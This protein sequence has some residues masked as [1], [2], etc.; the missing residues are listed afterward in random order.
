MLQ[1][2]NGQEQRESACY[3]KRHQYLQNEKS[4]LEKCCKPKYKFR[5]HHH[6]SRAKVISRDNYYNT[7]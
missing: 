7:K 4:S 2:I 1:C 6:G 5:L 3:G